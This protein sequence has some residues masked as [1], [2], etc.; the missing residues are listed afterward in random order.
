MNLIDIRSKFDINVSLVTISDMKKLA[1]GLYGYG[2]ENMEKKINDPEA[3][4][5]LDI[6][7]ERTL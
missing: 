2:V 7:I 4:K 5:S 6:Y 3:V 1:Y